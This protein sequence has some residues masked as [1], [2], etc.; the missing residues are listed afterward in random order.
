MLVFLLI[1][2]KIH[3]TSISNDLS[4]LETTTELL[5]QQQYRY[6]MNNQL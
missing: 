6:Y 2:T 4:F 1:Q 3:A 5:S